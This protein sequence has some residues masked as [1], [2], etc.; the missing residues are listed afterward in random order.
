MN[1]VVSFNHSLKYT[2]NMN[3]LKKIISSIYSPAFYGEIV[4]TKFTSAL[5]Y[6]LLLILL[7]TVVQ[8]IGLIKPVL[9]DLPKQAKTF[10]DEALVLYPSELEIKIKSGVVTTNV[11]EPYTIK[12]NDGTPLVVIDTKTPYTSAKFNELDTFCWVTSD[13]AFCGDSDKGP[14]KIRAVDLSQFPDTT[15]NKSLVE[16]LTNQSLPYLKYL[17]PVIIV[18]GLLGFYF[19]SSFRLLYLLIFALLILLVAKILKKKLSYG[20]SYKVGL[21]AMTLGIIVDVFKTYLGFAGFPF[22]FTLITLLV[23]VINLKSAKI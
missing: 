18:F 19:A 1:F 11:K 14:T 7:A 9:V 20:Q 17:G 10:V 2:K 16:S 22:M 8:A 6:F 3:F 5:G 21:Y 23:V 4:K 12:D 13:T 15:V